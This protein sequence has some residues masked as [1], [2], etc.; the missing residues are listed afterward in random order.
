MIKDK[1]A[2][3]STS[4][5]SAVGAQVGR[6][7]RQ[8]RRAINGQRQGGTGIRQSVL[9]ALSASSKAAK[10]GCSSSKKSIINTQSPQL[11]FGEMMQLRVKIVIFTGYLFFLILLDGGSYG[12]LGCQLFLFLI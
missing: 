6:I 7:I 1:S 4:Y 8:I 12:F 5:R 9:D 11:F 2:P 3:K 10:I